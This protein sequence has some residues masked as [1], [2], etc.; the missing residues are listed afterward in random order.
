MEYGIVV[1]GGTDSWRKGP[2]HGNAMGQ[3]DVGVCMRFARGFVGTHYLGVAPAYGELTERLSSASPRMTVLSRLAFVI[4]ILSLIW[5]LYAGESP[6]GGGKWA[7]A[8]RQAAD[9][10]RPDDYLERLLALVPHRAGA[11][12]ISRRSRSF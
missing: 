12:E 2:A 9:Q 11:T 5:S 8:E 6:D 3:C 1:G 7:Q 10:A 4:F